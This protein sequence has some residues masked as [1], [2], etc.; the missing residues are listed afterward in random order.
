MDYPSIWK[1]SGSSKI[2]IAIVVAIVVIVAGVAIALYAPQTQPTQPEQQPS[3]PEAEL[4]ITEV[5]VKYAELFK[6]WRYGHYIIVRDA[7]N[8]TFI[9]IPEG[10]SPPTEE[11]LAKMQNAIPGVEEAEMLNIPVKRAV[12]MSTTEVA[13]LYRLFKET[14]DASLLR[15]IAGTTWKEPW[16]FEELQEM[17]DNGTIT[18]CG[19][20]MNPDYE[21]IL[22]Q[23]PDLIIMYTGMSDM[24]RVMEKLKQLNLTV[25][26]DN[27]WIEQ[28]YLAR[29]EW[30]KFIAAFYGNETL[31]K[32]CE[33][34]DQV[35]STYQ[36]LMQAF[37]DEEK[38]DFVWVAP[39]PEWGIY[40]PGGKAY[41]ITFLE[42]IGG[43]Y[44][45]KHVAPNATGSTK[46]DKEVVLASL[47]EADVIILANYPP[48]LNSID[49]AAKIL[50]EAL[51]DT[52]AVKNQR[53]YFYGP[54]YWQLGYA[55]TEMVLKDLA[56]VLHPSHSAVKGYVRTFFHHMWRANESMQL[57]HAVGFKVEYYGFYKIIT[58]YVDNKWLTVPFDL[59]DLVPTDV[60]SQVK[61]VIELPVKRIVCGTCG[62]GRLLGLGFE[63]LIVGA[64]GYTYKYW[65]PEL[66]ELIEEGKI[67]KVG[68]VSKGL[69]YEEL[70]RVSPDVTI[71][72]SAMARRPHVIE[73]ISV[74]LNIP[75]IV[76]VNSR[77]V[78]P[79][80]FAE[81]IKLVGAV[82]DVEEHANS[83]Y[84]E[85]KCA[86]IETAE[87]IASSVAEKPTAIYCYYSKGTLGVAQP[88]EPRAKMLELAGAE[89]AL[90]GNAT[91]WIKMGIES[92]IGNF[93]DV[94][95]IVWIYPRVN[96]TSQ[97]IELDPRLSTLKAIQEGHVIVTLPLYSTYSKY[98][99]SI[100]IKELAAIL[101]P[102]LFP[103]YEVKLFQV[104]G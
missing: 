10:V 4:K 87:L 70:V 48:Y 14:G 33:I 27:E 65:P 86:I 50:G 60:K 66:L 37:K 32:A 95:W 52:P 54:S 20:N 38:V 29:F 75:V 93:S 58:D 74:E 72:G 71:H 12:Y 34:F 31:S 11:T 61:G 26:V 79:L 55:Y 40:V 46:V 104:A 9:L 85:E 96:S 80:G 36:Q 91:G 56:S 8:Q 16:W 78:D 101:H 3:G 53:V 19:S 35:E 49:E 68:C 59:V 18:Y 92:F 88:Q 7:E 82:L 51:L 62:A 90:K 57:E 43:N 84:E 63:N 45:L 2:T 17:V 73:K 69:N 39:Y 89:Y 44:L 77:E 98:K 28:S 13:L 30:I 64:T 99:L 97:I 83:V 23:N 25:A 102:E 21:T 42:E 103:G 47:Q 1:T 76:L 94:D 81:M 100:I 6:I 67:T 22:A 24:V 15:S 41:P 5:P